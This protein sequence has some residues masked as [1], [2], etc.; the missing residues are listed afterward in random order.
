MTVAFLADGLDVNNPDFIRADG[1]HVFVDYQDFSGDGANAPTY[2]AEAFGDASSI[3]AQGRQVYDL[4]TYVNPAHPLPAGCTIR[5]QGMA[6]DASLVGLK[7]FPSGGFAFSSAIL[8]AL[9]WAVTNDHADVINES[10]GSN[11]FP[12]TGD[13][14]TALFNEQLIRGG[15]TVVASSGDEGPENTIGSPASS[16]GVISVGGT[17]SFRSYAQTTESGFQLSNGSYRDNAISGLSSS[18]FTQAGRTIDLVAPGDLGWALCTPD[19]DLFGGCFNNAGEPSSIEEFGGTSQSSPFVAGAAALVIQA[20]RDSHGGS[21]PSPDLV[22]RLLTSTANDL[23]LPAQLQGAGLLDSLRAVQA[24]RSFPAPSRTA[25]AGHGDLVASTNQI[26][27]TAAPGGV[28]TAH[29]SVTNA[30]SKATV[31]TAVPRSVGRVLSR[32]DQTVALAAATDPKF[33]DSF[34]TA[35][36]FTKTTFPV[37]AGADHLRASIAWANPV[38]IVRLILLDPAGDYAGFSIPQRGHLD[39]RPLHRRVRCR[40]HRPRLPHGDLDGQRRCRDRPAACVPAR[41]RGDRRRVIPGAAAAHS[42]RRDG[43]PRPDE[44]AG[45][46]RRIERRRADRAAHI[47]PAGL[48]R[49]IVRRFVRRRQRTRWHP[50]PVADLRLRRATRR[51]VPGSALHRDR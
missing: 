45:G 11:Q 50:Q 16:P 26:N 9:D 28:A 34:G 30:S 21:S 15:V 3:A 42:G 2:G 47:G 38:A 46:R 33:I 12:D 20:Y 14:P 23:G 49:R 39:R 24:A 27:L 6:P 32:G 25:P 5:I 35:R 51:G 8:A 44:P 4:S 13:D 41:T 43:R 17:T 40:L 19:P 31:V 37:P 48:A 22:R 10:F 29:L 36:A 7:I 1:S 18:G